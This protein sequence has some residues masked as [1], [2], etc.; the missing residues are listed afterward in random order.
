MEE[1]QKQKSRQDKKQKSRQRANTKHP[2]KIKTEVWT[3]EQKRKSDQLKSVTS[4]TRN[5]NVQCSSPG[6]NGSFA[7]GSKSDFQ[8]S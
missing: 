8:M 2:D 5:L 4:P 1:R 3:I 7:L 6:K